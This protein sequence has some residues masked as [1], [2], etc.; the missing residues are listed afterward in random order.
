M[1]AFRPGDSDRITRNYTDSILIEMRHL[2]GVLPDTSMTVFGH[3]FS[4]P[5][6]T[7]AF[8]HLSQFG[9]HK[10]GMVE[11]SK[12]ACMANAL[13]FVGMGSE[14]ELERMVDTG[15]KIIKI[16]KPY[17]DNGRIFKKLEHAK[18]TGVIGV[19]MDIDHAF[20]G[21]GEYDVVQGDAMRPK[22]VEEIAAFA[23]ATGLPFVV[24]GVH[25]VT[26]A[27][28]CIEA[29]VHGIIVSHHHGI[30]D[31]AVP[32]LMI[33][34]DIVQAVDG[35]IPV[36]VDSGIANGY[37]VF[38]GLALGAIGACAGRAMLDSLKTGGKD[39]SSNWIKEQTQVLRSVMART[40]SKDIKS[41]DPT[42]LH[43]L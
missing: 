26:D 21:R 15:A 40:G 22:S 2:D 12:G 28:K 4:T 35:R 1:N 18:K 24:K 32:P 17:E 5:I 36:F 39:G 3:T 13:N 8:S 7:A 30:M 27:L 9:Y 43:Y 19:G 20:N 38:K 34:P 41:I 23:K 25:S 37:D 16:V 33:L 29:G 11:L 14:E 42:V 6:T 10:D 31:Y